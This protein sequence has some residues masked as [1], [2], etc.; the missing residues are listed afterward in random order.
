MY[1]LHLNMKIGISRSPVGNKASLIL[2]FE[3]W[4]NQLK[5]NL[6]NSTRI[7]KTKHNTGSLK[8]KKQ[9]KKQLKV[10]NEAVLENLQSMKLRTAAHYFH[11]ASQEG[12]AELEQLHMSR[13]FGRKVTQWS[14]SAK[15]SSLL[16]FHKK[17][18]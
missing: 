7:Y 16:H 10:D 6:L 13:K 14:F 4:S 9:T 2:D 3:S 5:L 15:Q 11:S 12:V 17:E 18:E 8:C 1:D